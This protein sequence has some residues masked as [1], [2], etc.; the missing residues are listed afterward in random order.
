MKHQLT[1]FPTLKKILAGLEEPLFKDAAV[2]VSCWS[3]MEDSVPVFH[4]D[5]KSAHLVLPDVT[6][7]QLDSLSK[8]F[9]I[10]V[11]HYFENEQAEACT[12]IF[13]FDVEVEGSE[14]QPDGMYQLNYRAHLED[15]EY[16]T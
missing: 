7:A 10:K 9:K 13:T 11:R 3:T 1:K 2:E 15:Y 5:E 6:K 14:Q 16:E 12:F 4:C 8:K